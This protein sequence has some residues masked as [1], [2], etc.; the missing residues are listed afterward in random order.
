MKFVNKIFP[1]LLLCFACSLT[2]ASGEVSVSSARFPN[3]FNELF[4]PNNELK[5]INKDPDENQDSHTISIRDNSPDQKEKTIYT[6]YRHVF[7]GWSPDSKYISITDFQESTNTTC[8]LY[9]IQSGNKIDLVKE[10]MQTNKSIAMIL[11]NEHAYLECSD[12]LTSSSVQI[13]VTAWGRN[14]PG[15]VETLYIYDINRGFQKN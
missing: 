2:K 10:A 7:V 13:K 14:N 12:W 9:N 3:T 6:Y 1:I 8:I 4:S 5:L 15:G 11:Q